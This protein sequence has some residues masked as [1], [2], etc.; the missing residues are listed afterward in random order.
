MAP[1]DAGLPAGLLGQW[2]V[3]ETPR[4]LAHRRQLARQAFALRFALHDEFALPG[5][6]AVATAVARCLPVHV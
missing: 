2:P 1:Q 5:P 6:S 3:H 4:F